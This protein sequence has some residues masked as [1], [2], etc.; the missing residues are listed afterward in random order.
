MSAG[1][2][3]RFPNFDYVSCRSDYETVNSNNSPILAPEMRSHPRHLTSTERQ[4]FIS[5]CYQC[6]TLAKLD[7]DARRNMMQQ[8]TLKRLCLMEEA[9]HLK[10][11]LGTGVQDFL[12]GACTTE[13]LQRQLNSQIERVAW[14]LNRIEGFSVKVW[15]EYYGCRGFAMAF[16][17]VQERLEEAIANGFLRTKFRFWYDPYDDTDVQRKQRCAPA[18]KLTGWNDFDE[19]N[20]PWLLTS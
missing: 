9:T 14:D 12:T 2:S 6:W 18:T 16:D 3:D 13:D 11:S 7:L 4:R 20:L 19:V 1:V 8:L 17:H 10:D 5:S 15:A